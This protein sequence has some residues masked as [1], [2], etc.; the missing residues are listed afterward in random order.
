VYVGA[1][2][3][4]GP[5]GLPGAPGRDGLPGLPGRQLRNVNVI[6]PIIEAKM[7]KMYAKIRVFHTYKNN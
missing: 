6:K 4:Q 7:K 5:P 3:P 2:G 1:R